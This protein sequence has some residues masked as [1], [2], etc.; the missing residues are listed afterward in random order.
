MAVILEV[1][2]GNLSLD[3]VKFMLHNPSVENW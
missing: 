2:S 1:A 3:Q